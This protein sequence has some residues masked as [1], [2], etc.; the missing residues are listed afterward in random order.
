MHGSLS[1][2]NTTFT[3]NSATGGTSD[4]SVASTDGLGRGGAIF[5]LN[6]SLSLSFSTIAGNGAPH[7]GRAVYDLAY[8]RETGLGANA[9]LSGDI[10][11]SATFGALDLR[12]DEPATVAG[13]GANEATATVTLVGGN[14]VR[15]SAA[16][17]GGEIVGP[18][19]AA[20]PQLASLA[21]NGGP[22]STMLPA[23]TSPALD[24]GGAS[25]PAT[26]ARG[27]AR[28]QDAACDLGAVEVDKPTIVT[29]PPPT[30][31]PPPPKPPS[32]PEPPNAKKVLPRPIGLAVSPRRDRRLPL[33]FAVS[34]RLRVPAGVEL[35]SACKGR[36]TVTLARR[37][38]TV[39]TK[40]P[41]LRLR[42]GRC[43]YS[44]R[45]VL[46]S[47]KRIG[48]RTR[49]LTIGARFPGN[50]VLRA[51]SAKRIS[52]RVR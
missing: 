3:G 52:V 46:R 39:A 37:A 14:I 24:A 23:D 32:L 1:A 27:V 44:T 26:D 48:T 18:I 11:S 20:D 35:A 15:S 13:G 28:P 29:D 25:C 40:K 34:G 21:A 17:G 5:N 4:A 7:G 8:H 38:K 22:V 47:R 31:P 41:R 43:T 30:A 2:V 36:M 33:R 51:R 12:V 19:T 42:A 50:A 16:F 6:G 9:V 10:L 45:V 49:K